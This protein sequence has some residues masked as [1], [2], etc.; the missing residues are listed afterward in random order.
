MTNERKREGERGREREGRWCWLGG[1]AFEFHC[2]T[3]EGF[4]SCHHNLCMSLDWS[5]TTARPPTWPTDN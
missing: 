1:L 5:W 3:T 4:G 2:V